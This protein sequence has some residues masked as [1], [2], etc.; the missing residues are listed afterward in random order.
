MILDEY[1]KIP[2]SPH[3]IPE[4][5]TTEPEQEGARRFVLKRSGQMGIVGVAHKTPEG[6][7]NDSYAIQILSRILGSGKSSR[8]YKKLV[9][10]G[11]ATRISMFDYPFKDN[12]LLISYVF[13][14]PGTKHEDVEKIILDEL[15]PLSHL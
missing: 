3:P 7:N 4:M 12:G 8:F 1:G 14:T 10:K 11:L 13:L 2:K 15:G 9:D 6:L 5:Y